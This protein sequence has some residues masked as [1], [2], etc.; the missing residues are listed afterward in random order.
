MAKTASK[1]AALGSAAPD[2]A[3]PDTDGR[4]VRRDDF[5]EAPA[6]LVAFW[7]NHCPFVQHIREAFVRFAR[8]YQPKGLAVV[9]ISANDPLAYPDDAPERMREVAKKFGFGFPFLFDETQAV[10]RAYQAACTPDFFLYDAALRLAYRGQ[11][12]A[13]RPGNAVPVTGADLRA[14]ADAVLAGRPASAEQKPS[15]GCN[16]KWKSD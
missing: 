8:E 13:S 4:T 16:I 14:A 9:A 12:D 15:I 2:F 11:F 3:L 7:C 10:A 1:M 6:L 5:S